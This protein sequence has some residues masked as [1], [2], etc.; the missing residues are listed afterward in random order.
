LRNN[1]LGFRTYN[2]LKTLFTRSGIREL[3][4]S[5]NIL[6]DEGI[7]DLFD[8]KY[9]LLRKLNLSNVCLRSQGLILLFERLKDNKDLKILI[10]DK[11]DFSDNWFIKIEHIISTNSS[12]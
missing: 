8:I 10:L 2:I 6:S 3:N 9:S 5:D 11:N 12:L 1:G 4:L 7:S